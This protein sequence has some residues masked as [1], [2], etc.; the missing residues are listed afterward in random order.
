MEEVVEFERESLHVPAQTTAR[1]DILYTAEKVTDSY[2]RS[3]NIA[4][5]I[6]VNLTPTLDKTIKT[7]PTPALTQGLH[8]QVQSNTPMPTF[9]STTILQRQNSI[10]ADNNVTNGSIS[11]IM[12]R[13]EQL[14]R[15]IK[16]IK[17]D[18][19]RNLR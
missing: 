16:A 2:K 14:D 12:N 1:S 8:D 11:L 6:G 17:R 13:I 7:Q 18:V 10:K 5:S 3:V 19:I 15:G 9:T 4:S